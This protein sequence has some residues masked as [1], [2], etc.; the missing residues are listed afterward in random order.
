MLLDS[1]FQARIS[2]FE[3]AKLIN[4]GA[5]H[6]NTI[7]KGSLGYLAP[8]YAIFGKVSTSCDVYSL[9]ILLLELVSGKKPIEKLNATT[10]VLVYDWAL[11]LA[12]EKKFSELADPKLKGNYVEEELEIVILV[13]LL[14]AQSQPENRPTMLEVV[15]LLKVSSKDT[16]SRLQ[17]NELFRNRPTS[18]NKDGASFG[19]N[20]SHFVSK[21]KEIFE[22]KQN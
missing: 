19:D 11:S 6:V 18:E 16:L 17:K 13:G 20:N 2:G 3:F 14:C 4:D 7:V 12:C 1:N 9:G 15:E 8:E 22:M 10:K 21:E 5:T